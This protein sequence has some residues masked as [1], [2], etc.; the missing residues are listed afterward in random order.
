MFPTTQ[1]STTDLV[2]ALNNSQVN[3]TTA[4]GGKSFMQF[5]FKTGGFT[6]G[7]E[8]ESITGETIVVNTGSFSHGWIIWVGNS[9]K[10]TSVPFTQPL[11]IEPAPID[12]N[13]A[14]ESRSFEARFLDDED[15]ILS[16]DTNSYGGRKGCDNLLTAIKLRANSGE[17][18]YLYPIVKLESENYRA[19]QGGIIH[20]PVFTITGWM[21]QAGEVQDGQAVLEKDP[22][23][24]QTRRR[25]V[26]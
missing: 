24:A 17:S 3:T 21:N 20:N 12:G 11:P 15:T 9:P 13:T 10:K 8:K 23:P 5:D 7:R 2:S 22:E 6:F 14:S 1:N 16:F 26:A 18:E 4:A 25:R 19:Q